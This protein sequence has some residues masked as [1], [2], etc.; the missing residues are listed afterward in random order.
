LAE[1][2]QRVVLLS[3]PASELSQLCD[4]L[5]KQIESEAYVF[6]RKRLELKSSWNKTV[7]AEL[8]KLGDEYKDLAAESRRLEA[9]LIKYELRIAAAPEQPIHV[10]LTR[11]F[12]SEAVLLKELPMLQKLKEAAANVTGFQFTGAHY[13][14]LRRQL[15]IWVICCLSNLSL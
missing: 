3:T 2:E 7:D 15:R 8:A 11:A 5:R 9:S 1:E 10:S 14:Q 12:T 4:F 6:A 13:V